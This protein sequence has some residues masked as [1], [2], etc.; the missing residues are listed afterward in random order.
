VPHSDTVDKRTNRRNPPRLTLLRIMHDHLGSFPDPYTLCGVDTVGILRP[1][2]LANG[3]PE[4]WL[5]TFVCHES[6]PWRPI[7]EWIVGYSPITGFWKSG[8]SSGRYS[9]SQTAKA[10]QT[11]RGM[12]TDF[13]TAAPSLLRF[14]CVVLFAVDISMVF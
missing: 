4:Q 7:S 13:P 2:A 10:S 6:M 8:P 14:P 11:E 5:Y 1:S 3:L 12:A 9:P